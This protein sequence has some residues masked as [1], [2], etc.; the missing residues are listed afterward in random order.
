MARS[1]GKGSKNAPRAPAP[2]P[3]PQKPEDL[4]QPA[5]Q[6]QVL[7][8]DDD[9][10]DRMTLHRA[11][12]ESRLNPLIEEAT[13][14]ASG[15][16]AIR[17]KA[18]DVVILDHLLPDGKSIDLLRTLRDAKIRVPIV[19][20]TG[21]GDEML[22][23]DL[24]KTG[25]L[26]YLPKDKISADALS[27]AIAHA[28]RVH[29]AE[30]DLRKQELLLQGVAQAATLLETHG[31]RLTVVNEALAILGNATH[32][33]RAIVFEHAL[34][35]SRKDVLISHRYEWNRGSEDFIINNPALQNTTYEVLGLARYQAALAGG[36]TVGGPARTLPDA[37]R[38][39][40]EGEG[41][42]SFLLMPV[43]VDGRYWGFVKLDDRHADRT[44]TPNEKAILVAMASGIGSALVHRRAEETLRRSEELYRT[45]VEDQTDLLCRFSTGC[46]LTFVNEA[47]C[48]HFGRKR[49][50]LVG[51]NFLDLIPESERKAVW[52]HLAQLQWERPVASI[53]YAVR[54]PDGALHWQMWTSQ[55]IF[56]ARGQRVK[57][58][59]VGRD[60][61]D[62]RGAERAPADTETKYR[63]LVEQVPAIIYT[64]AIDKK[65]STQ[66]V[67]PQVET[68]LGFTQAD[69]KADPDLWRKQLHP[70]DRDRVMAELDR[71]AKARTDFTCEYRM[72]AKDGHIVWFHDSG[73]CL[74]DAE[75]KPVSLH[76]VMYDISDRKRAEESARL[77]E[78]RWRAQYR[79]F[80]IPTFTWQKQG[81]DFVLSDFN[82]AALAI[83]RG[84]L[85][86]LKGE[87]LSVV[88]KDRPDAVRDVWQC[89][90]ER[91]TLARETDY[92]FVTTG[93]VKRLH[94]TCVFTPPD[95]VMVHT[96]DIT[97]RWKAEQALGESKEYLNKIIN[98]IGDPVFVKDEQHRL[99]LVNDAE[100]ALTGHTREEVAGKTDYDFFPKAQVDVFWKYD[101]EV[102]S[103]G[104]ENIN[105]EEITDAQGVL[106]TIIT[107]KTRYVD[108]AG[109]KFIVGVVRDIT[110]RKR[111]ENALRDSES[112][113]R[114]LA[115]NA[116]DGILILGERGQ[117]VYAN[118]RAAEITGYSVEEICGLG[119]RQLVHPDQ[120][121]SIEAQS[122]A[123]LA[124]KAAPN[125][126]ETVI[127]RKDGRAV[128]VEVSAALTVWK[129]RP[130]A[131][132]I[133]RDIGNQKRTEEE[134]RRLAA[135]LLEVQEEERKKISAMLHDHLGQLLTLTRLELGSVGVQD[136]ASKKSVDSALQRLDEALGSVRRLA[137]SLRPPI[138]DDLGVQA[139]LETLTEEF[140]DGSGIET[141]F[142][143]TGRAPELSNAE[144]TCLYRVLQEALTNAVKH[145]AATVIEVT[146][147]TDEAETRLEV[148]DNGKGFDTETPGQ[149]GLGVIG[150]RERLLQCGGSLDVESGKG[151]GTTIVAHVPRKKGGPE[152][153]PA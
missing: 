6:L 61:T 3:T 29:R 24:L 95:Q 146:L 41:V 37:E 30:E 44:W 109:N 118:R 141:S 126:Y 66:Y 60:T 122:L 19:V 149:K 85:G 107:R 114:A 15:L 129:G 1:P 5:R 63:V 100:C 14:L 91:K 43:I 74:S 79:A 113:F 12:E 151:S 64:A 124:G 34:A 111:A 42:R 138:L 119:V 120:S 77:N 70:E 67:S 36:H 51:R 104:V 130:A 45:I 17:R 46:V 106:R 20:T 93:E 52:S 75:D 58:Q 137:V 150:M 112:N 31:D 9:P 10:V 28:I 50:E 88:H 25:A 62:W 71:A 7:V 22:V 89:F 86:R 139:A 143:R 80:P 92:R 23:V 69:Y 105:E 55:A 57:F 40:F 121:A 72:F 49:E 148:R 110:D 102:L 127:V 47:F 103:T 84:A 99:V 108:P 117:H 4:D 32:V 35:P 11:L 27:R 68:I 73:S 131:L 135:S 54:M 13:D 48:R 116:M 76:G 33:D 65:S 101:D 53:E 125:R 38:A 132:A 94:V 81:D 8:I 39:R 16:E 59:S 56:D 142:R 2:H 97:D 152:G 82:D 140:A 147:R 90:N 83:T 144:E 153:A 134:R 145:S 123:R 136:E 115:D 128:P 78:E 26:D 98:S 133:M 96:D 87:R 18:Y 21:Y